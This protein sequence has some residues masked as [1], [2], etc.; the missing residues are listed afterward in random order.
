MKFRYSICEYYGYI[1][2][3]YINPGIYILSTTYK[4]PMV[5]CIRDRA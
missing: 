4:G 3:V 2:I 5:Y 1:I